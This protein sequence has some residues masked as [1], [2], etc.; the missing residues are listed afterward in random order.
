MGRSASGCTADKLEPGTPR[1]T[2]P[3]DRGAA[4]GSD[5]MARPLRIKSVEVLHGFVVRLGLTDQSER[6][7][8]LARYL[9]GPVFESI[10][11]NP[12]EF[13]RV[14]VDHRAGTIVWPN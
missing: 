12:P 7:V 10:R 14:Q 13:A 5:A 4:V 9:R 3:A 1:R 6:I 8:D 11:A 2:T